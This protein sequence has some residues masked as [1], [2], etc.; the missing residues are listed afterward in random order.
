MSASQ[1][2]LKRMFEEAERRGDRDT[3]AAVMSRLEN[4]EAPPKSPDFGERVE[5]KLSARLDQVN[6]TLKDHAEGKIGTLQ[7]GAQ[8]VGK[9]LAG[10]AVDIIGEETIDAIKGINMIVPS[11]VKDEVK[12]TWKWFSD[13]EAGKYAI[14]EFSQSLKGGLKGYKAF[15]DK[16]PQEA[17]TLEAI[18]N[19][20]IVL[21]PVKIKAN[22]S[23]TILG[24]QA[25]K[26]NRSAL[27]SQLKNRKKF[28]QDLVSPEQ[29]KKVKIAET[30]RTT[31]KGGGLLKRSVVEPS[32]RELSIANEVRRIKTVTPKN[33]IQGNLNEIT[34]HNELL[35]KK[36]DVALEKSKVII[37]TKESS[38]AIDGAI[39]KLIKENP[40]V[41]GDA[42]RVAERVAKK[43]KELLSE[44]PSTAKGVMD[45]RKQLDNWIKRQ[46]GKKAFDPSMENSLSVS[47]REVRKA[48]NDT[49]ERAI[50][51][52]KVKDQLRRQ[53]LLF[54]AVENLGPKAA[55]E[56]NHAI[57]RA[58]QNVTKVLPYKQATMGEMGLLFG[59]GYVSASETFAPIISGLAAAGIAVYGAG[60]LIINPNARKGISKLLSMTDRALLTSKNPAMIKQLRA[61]RAL[62]VELLK[63]SEVE[64]Q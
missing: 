19:I 27:K 28:I 42:Q 33:T 36:L 45:A 11:S 49:V 38:N 35:A 43:A 50:P 13:T 14:N 31:E 37:T 59:M 63:N 22:A 52:E 5:K 9:G 57:A 51:S 34:K 8:V 61:D 20:G 24:K 60:R 18:T 12:K 23:P 16:F 29:T 25:T 10:S 58:W 1:D 2:D 4:F 17:K 55:I 3:A 46:K 7:A 26:L 21:A 39:K 40:V 53:S 44:N 15:K 48:M 6:R 56:K 32:A 41:V 62:I 54:D 30:A 64:E 47:V